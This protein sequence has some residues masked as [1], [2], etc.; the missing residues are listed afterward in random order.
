MSSSC[1]FLALLRSRVRRLAR[2]PDVNRAGRRTERPGTLS[3][4]PARVEP[5][6]VRLAAP[7]ADR[8]VSEPPHTRAPLVPQTSR[9][10]SVAR[11]GARS[12]REAATQLS[13]RVRTPSLDFSRNRRRGLSRRR[14][15]VRVPSLPSLQVPA[16]RHFCC[17]I[18]RS[19]AARGPIP[20]PKRF[21][22]KP[23]K[24]AFC[25]QRLES[26]RTNE[27][28]SETLDGRHWRDELQ[29][30]KSG[31]MRNRPP[32]KGSAATASIQAAGETLLGHS[33]PLT[34][35]ESP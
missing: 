10:R 8:D 24:L 28:G 35:A 33:L 9:N 11:C 14:S 30:S 7:D 34:T 1:A 20:W 29:P 15:R 2:H 26:G 6:P 18:R 13:I 12:P 32:P 19:T 25:C 16:N 22:E 21:G 27:N 4:N 5:R 23:C 17:P 3:R 31:K